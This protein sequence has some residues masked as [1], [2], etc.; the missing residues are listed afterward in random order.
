MQYQIFEITSE[1]D[2][3]ICKVIKSVGIEF[4]AIGEGF[5]PSDN[6]VLQMS[7]HYNDRY[8]SKYLLAA[9]DGE[10]VG[11]CGIAKFND[12]PE[13]CELKKLFLTPQ[14]RGNGIGKQLCLQLIAYAKGVGYQQCYLDTLANMTSAIALYESL[15]FNHRQQPLTGT[16]HNS[17]DIWMLKK[18]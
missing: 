14:S 17:C 3:D 15:G 8:Q 4:G 12:N 1:F 18:L 5:G 7:Q 13:I 2:A 6:E 11:G 10:I 9:I 16:V